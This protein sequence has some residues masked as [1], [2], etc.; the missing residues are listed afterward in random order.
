MPVRCH[1]RGTFRAPS[2]GGAARSCARASPTAQ[3]SRN[4][5]SRGT[6]FRINAPQRLIRAVFGDLRT[7]PGFR[8]RQPLAPLAAEDLAVVLLEWDVAIG[9]FNDA[10]RQF[11]LDSVNQA[12]VATHPRSA[13]PAVH[14]KSVSAVDAPPR[15]GA[16]KSS[17]HHVIP[18]CHMHIEG[19]TFAFSRGA[20]PGSSSSNVFQHFGCHPYRPTVRACK[21]RARPRAH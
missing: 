15:Y 3:V 6:I 17:S 11:G 16:I 20:Q 10:G 21:P 18:I 14:H 8:L 5:R 13:E 2:R 9:A 1:A 7:P 19:M 4:G 12:Y